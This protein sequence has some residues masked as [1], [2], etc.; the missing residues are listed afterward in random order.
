MD[1]GQIKLVSMGFGKKRSFG[2]S[3]MPNFGHWT[4]VSDGIFWRGVVSKTRV[5]GTFM[6]SHCSERNLCLAGDHWTIY[7]R[8]ATGTPSCTL[9][10]VATQQ[11]DSKEWLSC[12]PSRSR[13]F[14]LCGYQRG[15]GKHGQ[16]Q[17]GAAHVSPCPTHPPQAIC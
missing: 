14:H 7:C 1:F 9:E 10:Y 2:L 11:Q 16:S 5:L 4:Y 15:N 12:I 8:N 13:R 6:T 3:G 17:S